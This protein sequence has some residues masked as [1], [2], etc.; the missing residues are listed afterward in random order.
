MMTLWMTV[1][2]VIDENDMIIDLIDIDLNI[3]DEEKEEAQQ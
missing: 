1:M 3:N 2:V